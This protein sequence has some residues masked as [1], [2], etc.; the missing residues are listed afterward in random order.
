MPEYDQSVESK[1][2]RL[3]RDINALNVHEFHYER[4]EFLGDSVLDMVVVEY[5]YKNYSSRQPG[6]L[7]LMK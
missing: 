6:D 4:L 5:L 2:E 7:S 3:H 1:L